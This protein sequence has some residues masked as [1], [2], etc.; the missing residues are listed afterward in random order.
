MHATGGGEA[1][2]HLSY[3]LAERSLLYCDCAP[4]LMAEFAQAHES[5]QRAPLY[6]ATQSEAWV[7]DWS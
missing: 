4:V 1:H 7:Q 6:T 2:G 3:V 5:P